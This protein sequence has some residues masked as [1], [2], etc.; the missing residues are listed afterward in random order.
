MEF[1]PP[2]LN[3]A[4]IVAKRQLLAAGVAVT[5]EV[6]RPT[7]PDG[8]ANWFCPWRVAGEDSCQLYSGGADSMQALILALTAAGD[9][10]L[11]THGPDLKSLG[12]DDHNL[13]HTSDSP[14][15]GYHV[16]LLRSA[17]VG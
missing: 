6:G 12:T 17:T 1:A 3:E 8:G 14:E 5:V 7:S 15:P 10:A 13:L 4:E 11:A 9:Y 2:A 16:A